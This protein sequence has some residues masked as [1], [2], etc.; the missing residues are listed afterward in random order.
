[1]NYLANKTC[2]LSGA[3]SALTDNGKKWREEITNQLSLFGVNI[4]DPTRK[5]NQFLEEIGENKDHFRELIRL[6]K[7]DEL[8]KVFFPVARWDLRAVDKADFLIVN[9]NPEVPSVGTIDE[10]VIAN[11]E[12][13]PILVKYNKNQLEHFNPW[14]VVRVRPEH[15]FSSW[16]S[17]FT[18][19]SE[20]NNGKYEKDCWTL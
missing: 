11:L 8:K 19:L 18:Y 9:Y 4:L 12:Q 7:F 5:S 17:M 3:M 13:K 10:I 2:Y 1:M 6:E 15:M 16:I 14:L 20:V